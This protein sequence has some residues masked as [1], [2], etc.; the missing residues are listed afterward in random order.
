MKRIFLGLTIL[1]AGTPCIAMDK[2]ITLPNAA[3]LRTR[4]WDAW[5]DHFVIKTNIDT[6][7]G[8]KTLLPLQVAT[9]VETHVNK[10]NEYVMQPMIC[11]MMLK[12]K[13]EIVELILQDHPEAIAALKS[14]GTI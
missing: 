10:Y 9:A 4:L 3:T 8:N 12:R 13:A 14:Q 6:D 5:F 11:R 1:C 7:L 2:A